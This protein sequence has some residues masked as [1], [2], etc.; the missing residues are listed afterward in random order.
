MQQIVHLQTTHTIRGLI[1][2]AAIAVASFCGSAIH[3]RSA[4]V[5]PSQG[6]QP[7]HIDSA[8]DEMAKGPLETRL[9]D[10]PFNA[11]QSQYVARFTDA[12]QAQRA[13]PA[14][15][16]AQFLMGW[17]MLPEARDF[18]SL[19][20][21]STDTALQ[22]R[23][24]A[25]LAMIDVLSG[26][27]VPVDDFPRAMEQDP[28]WSV[29]LDL[30]A[31]ASVTETRLHKAPSKL[32]QH[33]PAVSGRLVP[34]IFAAA[35]KAE[36]LDFARSLLNASVKGTDLEGTSDML[37]MRGILARADGQNQT[38]FDFFAWASEHQDRAAA[39]ARIELAD[40]ALEH[41][42]RA[43]RE[44]VRDLLVEGLA[45]WRGDDL[46]LRMRALL[47]RVSEDLGDAETAIISMALIHADHP[48]TPE[49]ELAERRIGV[50]LNILGEAIEADAMSLEDSLA[51]VRRIEPYV[52]AQ[53]E[54]VLVHGALANR[55]SR[56]GLTLA[57]QAEYADIW[58]GLLETERDKIPP[59]LL[60]RLIL[61]QA[62]RYL[63]ED[64]PAAAR[65]E[66]YR[67][68]AERLKSLDAEFAKIELFAGGKIPVTDN[69]PVALEIGRYALHRGDTAAALEAL[70]Q[71]GPLPATDGINAA[72]IAASQ[73]KTNVT[74]Y[75]SDLSKE[76]REHV[77]NLSK[78]RAAEAPDISPL[79][80]EAARGI[81]E[82]ATV[83]LDA[84]ETLNASN[85]S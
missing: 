47:A 58:D 65:N 12:P 36:D 49:A 74:D 24:K 22:D 61:E 11:A 70:D 2:C 80:V 21:N 38:A 10:I 28:L 40:M 57:A 19:A 3:A 64:I 15:D 18:A 85:G 9:A 29:V 8:I 13:A 33:S 45:R 62:K 53:P 35:I 73:G 46:A 68:P 77:V 1:G 79:S 6:A 83:A 27:S 5:Q 14:L 7:Q 37:L 50:I 56:A 34:I 31:G 48:G 59:A 30:Q 81:I 60:D 4:D 78:I 20:L 43:V 41:P 16:Y 71:A 44:R 26:I 42:D 51:A 67:R 17:L 84:V 75:L 72:R 52:S 55:F 25:T 39:Q 23:A 76:R 63:R 54:R 66:I 32:V 69:A 82:R